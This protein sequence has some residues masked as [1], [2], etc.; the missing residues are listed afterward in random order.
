MS[1]PTPISGLAVGL[2][3]DYTTGMQYEDSYAESLAAY[4]SFQVT[5][6]L[7][8]NG[9][10]DW[11]KGYNGSPAGG[12]YNGA[13]GYTSATDDKNELFSATVTADYALWKNVISRLEFRWD[14]SLTDDSPFGGTT[15]ATAGTPLVGGDESAVS[16][17]AN[18]IYQ[19]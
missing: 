8:L 3:F 11:A 15:A 17:T 19:F 16:L 2:A 1:L 6:K 13:F 18:F 4:V 12:G 7:K 14:T 5:E 10:A 9:R